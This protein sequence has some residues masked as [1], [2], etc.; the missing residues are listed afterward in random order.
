MNIRPATEQDFPRLYEIG[1]Q[2]PELRV[3]ATES[4]MDA[5]EFKWAITEY[6]NAVF[7][8]AELDGSI[9]GFIY[10][11]AKDLDKPV[12]HK[13]ACLVYMTVLPEFRKQGI[14]KELYATCLS[15]LKSKGITHMYGWANAESDGAIISFLEKE[16]FAKGHKYVWMDREIV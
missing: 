3:S 14:A 8:I 7:L 15:E 1:S 4:F 12:K 16:G 5:D 2:T 13:Y 11:N 10:A 9:V 6:K